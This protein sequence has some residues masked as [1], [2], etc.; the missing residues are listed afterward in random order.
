MFD[1]PKP[2]LIFVGEGEEAL[3]IKTG[4]GLLEWRGDWCRGQ[5]RLTQ[6]AYDLGLADMSPVQARD[7]GLATM[8]I[9]GATFGGRLTIEWHAAVAKALEAGLNVASGLHDRLASY[10]DLVALAHKNGVSL[11]DVRGLPDGFKPPVGSGRRRSGR[12]VLTVGTD[13]AVG[14][15]YTALCLERDMHKRGINATFRATGQTGVLISGGG[16]AIDAVVSDFLAGV[17][18]SLSPD[19][20]SEHWDII[21]GQGALHHPAYGAVSLGLLHGSQPDVFIV[22]H[23]VGR[24][25]LLGYPG[26]SVP[27]IQDCIEL[28][29]HNAKRINPDIQCIGVSLNCSALDVNQRLEALVALE[30]A[31][32]LPVVDPAYGTDRLIDK[33]LAVVTS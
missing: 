4:L 23:E 15:K 33:M 13:C 16:I 27:S 21:E 30:H 29:V 2:Y 24:P 17:V 7:N 19:A 28:N 14:K 8:V 22:C 20:S 11:F 1:I 31:T 18:E 12:R 9:G 6:S 25:E 3:D 5:Y 26:V 10:P 32:G